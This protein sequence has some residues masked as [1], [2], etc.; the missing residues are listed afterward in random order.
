MLS[1]L[2][3]A[4][5]SGLCSAHVLASK[6]CSMMPV[7]GRGRRRFAFRPPGR[8]CAPNTRH[9]TAHDVQGLG[10]CNAGNHMYGTERVCVYTPDSSFPSF[11]YP[12]CPLAQLLNPS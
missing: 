4:L 6:G 2:L 5:G 7:R 3:W 12:L 10:Q 8:S 1:S 9:L 11:I